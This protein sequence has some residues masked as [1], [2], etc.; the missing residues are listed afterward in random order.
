MSRDK[1]FVESAAPSGWRI[2]T[3][4]HL[5]GMALPRETF[6]VGVIRNF[7]AVA[8]VVPTTIDDDGTRHEQNLSLG[9]IQID[10]HVGPN[11]PESQLGGTQHRLAVCRPGRIPVRVLSSLMGQRLSALAP[12]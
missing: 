7:E 2:E 10:N 3:E 1:V 9:E 4:G 6:R 8:E 12:V 5:G 11:R